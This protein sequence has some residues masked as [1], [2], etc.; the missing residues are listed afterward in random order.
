MSLFI[1]KVINRNLDIKPIPPVHLEILQSWQ[2]M[3]TSKNMA[4]HKETAVV[5][6]FISKFLERQKFKRF[7]TSIM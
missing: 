7:I 2:E 4:K 1:S 5:S 3:I 6:S